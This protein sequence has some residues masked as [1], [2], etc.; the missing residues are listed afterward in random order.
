M[1][2][3]TVKTSIRKT[4]TD[5]SL[6]GKSGRESLHYTFYKI[7]SFKSRRSGRFSVQHS[8]STD[9]FADLLEIGGHKMQKF[10]T[11]ISLHCSYAE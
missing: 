8:G 7:E 2:S 10:S 4:N 11:K 9:F 3:E 6:G 5:E 1:A